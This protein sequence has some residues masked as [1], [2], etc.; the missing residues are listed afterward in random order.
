MKKIISLILVISMIATFGALSVS[1]DDI[2]TLDASTPSEDGSKKENWGEKIYI[3]KKYFAV[4]YTIHDLPA[5]AGRGDDNGCC[6]IQ[7]NDDDTSASA[8]SSHGYA[9]ICYNPNSANGNCD[10]QNK[11]WFGPWWDD[12]PCG[13]ANKWVDLNADTV[14]GK[15]LTVVCYGSFENATLKVKTVINGEAVQSWGADEYTMENA[16]GCV[17][18]ATKVTNLSATFK[19]TESDS[20]LGADAFDVKEAPKT[21]ST[22]AIVA[23]IAVISLAGTMVASKKH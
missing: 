9:F 22:V 12:S 7:F 15:D 5:T 19:F 14:V 11:V 6:G 3:E 4:S 8:Q 16:T 17:N 1:A 20:P 2:T 21:G 13:K 23:A 18:F 10:F